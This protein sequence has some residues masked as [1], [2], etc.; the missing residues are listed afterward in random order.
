MQQ[1]QIE[2][3]ETKLPSLAPTQLLKYAN[4]AQ[5]LQHAGQWKN[6]ESSAVFL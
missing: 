3:L 2:Y 6:T 1:L 4:K 5:V